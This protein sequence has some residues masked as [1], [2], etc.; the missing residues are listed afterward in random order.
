M[1]L[2]K[3]NEIRGGG[4]SLSAFLRNGVVVMRRRA[5]GALALGL[6]SA[7]SFAGLAFDA[8]YTADDTV[9]ISQSGSYLVTGTGGGSVTVSENVTGAELTI[10]NVTWTGNATKINIG[11]GAS[12]SLVLEG[13]SSIIHTGNSSGPGIKLP[14]TSSLTVFGTGELDMKVRN[15]WPCIGVGKT[16]TMGS[17]TI[18]GGT[19]IAYAEQGLSAAI[20]GGYGN[21]QR[22]GNGGTVVVNGGKLVAVGYS[23]APGIGGGMGYGAG[24]GGDAGTL[25]VNGGHVIAMTRHLGSYTGGYASPAIGPGASRQNV[26]K[27]GAPGRITVTGG[28][29]EAW[30]D[31]AEASCFGIARN[32]GQAA[33]VPEGAGLFVTGGT[34]K[35]NHLIMD[36]TDFTYSFANCNVGCSS[37]PER[38]LTG[39]WL[40][41]DADIATLF[42]AGV[43]FEKTPGVTVAANAI[44]LADLAAG[45]VA[46][47]S[48]SPFTLVGSSAATANKI[49]ASGDIEAALC[50]VN[51]TGN[52]EVPANSMS[53]VYVYGGNEIRSGSIA[54]TLPETG[55]LAFKGAG[56]LFCDASGN[57]CAIGVGEASKWGTLI[58]DGPTVQADGCYRSSGVGLS[59]SFNASRAGAG[60]VVVESGTLIANGRGFAPAIGGGSVH[61]AAPASV[62][63]EVIVKTNGT[64]YA[65]NIVDSSRS[66]ISGNPEKFAAGVAIGGGVRRQ[67]AE[68]AADAGSIIVDGGTIY[69]TVA[70]AAMPCFGIVN[71]M[72]T[73][74][75][76]PN[77]TGSL[78]IK[79]GGK[80]FFQH[81]DFPGQYTVTI[82][83]GT[84]GTMS[85][86]PAA[87]WVAFNSLS[88][89]TNALT[90]AG[91]VEPELTTL[92]SFKNSPAL[93]LET[94]VNI[95]SAMFPG[96][97]VEI[98]DME[99]VTLSSSIM[100]RMKNEDDRVLTRFEA[101]EGWINLAEQTG[102]YEITENG[103]YKFYGTGTSPVAIRVADNVEC[104]TVLADASINVDGGSVAPLELGAGSR[105]S[106][107]LMGANTMNRIGGSGKYAVI[108]V[109]KDAELTISDGAEEGEATGSLTIDETNLGTD[110]VVGIG[111]AGV[112]SQMGTL[113]I[114]SGNITITMKHDNNIHGGAAIGSAG[115]GSSCGTVT[116]NGGTVQLDGP[117]LGPAIGAGTDNTRMGH[118][119]NVTINGG[120]V[121][122]KGY[123]GASAIGLAPTYAGGAV[124]T[125]G[126]F[127]MNGG[128][129]FAYAKKGGSYGGNQCGAAI[130]GSGTRNGTTGSTIGQVTFNGG[131]AY[132]FSEG[133]CSIGCGQSS[134]GSE[135]VAR[136]ATDRVTI[137]GGNVWAEQG[138]QGDAVNA[139][140]L[141]LTHVAIQSS[142]FPSFPYTL[143]LGG[144]VAYTFPQTTFNDK[145]EHLWLPQGLCEPEND[146]AI[147]IG[148]ADGET[149]RSY[150][151][152][153]GAAKVFVVGKT[154]LS[155]S[156][157][158]SGAGVIVLGDGSETTF[159]GLD[160]TSVSGNGCHSSVVVQDGAT[161]KVILKGENS[162]KRPVGGDSVIHL[163]A[164]S[165]LTIDG[166]EDD[167][168]R[169]SQMTEGDSVGIGVANYD[170]TLSM[171]TFV[172]DGGNVEIKF[173][174]GSGNTGNIGVALGV[175]SGNRDA[176]TVI[177]NGG[178]LLA[179]SG[180][181]SPGIGGGYIHNGVAGSGGTVIVNGGVV[182]AKGYGGSAGIGG[183]TTYGNNGKCGKGGSF[184]LNG[185]TVYAYAYK[186][187]KYGTSGHCGAAI[188][189]PAQRDKNEAGGMGTVTINDGTLYAYTDV[190]A[191]IGHGN[192][193]SDTATA[194]IENGS[195]GAFTING[196]S[197]KLVSG[198]GSTTLYHVTPKNGTLE[199]PLVRVPARKFG[200]APYALE[201][202][203]KDAAEGATPFTY[204]YHGAGYGDDDSLYFYMPYGKYLMNGRF[205]EV[206]E[207]GVRF[208]GMT[209]I[210][211]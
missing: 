86:T 13:A 77:G 93:N 116:I 57:N 97:W 180:A 80:V 204:S 11:D 207:N 67:N 140:G 144:S 183:G 85:D 190:G 112:D 107:Q 176:G 178:T 69:A 133:A 158:L 114:D 61:K 141:T 58:V 210:V 164:G 46:L 44:G 170:K 81:S 195:D 191:A 149:P 145:L 165:K 182:T 168:L 82:D 101:R 211:K 181:L 12:L 157:A 40:P 113:T 92:P 39:L 196:G 75:Q 73:G 148:G 17:L 199:P 88:T 134:N 34:V 136:A 6:A 42:P 37:G 152:S 151:M 33:T 30:V 150:T 24:G 68:Y 52:W 16:E 9:T 56:W 7:L 169:I 201:F 22:G 128:T 126:T 1:K 79:N 132:L 98:G 147:V 163:P 66:G 122:A 137:T 203:E 208:S 197:V 205:C 156:S 64:L 59:Y 171:G 108:R 29:L 51:S 161:A 188:G 130:G 174:P 4:R 21:P 32:V 10:S 50:G 53:T 173:N 25:T 74:V 102:V 192:M 43:S 72:Q 3:M 49:V 62:G 96:E 118:G 155:S 143:D 18:N 125:P 120:T 65:N 15:F 127:T 106:L 78:T 115:R 31:R 194:T 76:N 135:P 91:P 153:S 55:T 26:A 124:G 103:E 38:K 202:V 104:T 71:G 193:A 206:A 111:E 35:W 185:G 162:L 90:I 8:E 198:S 27:H 83:D 14:Q 172:L 105:V 166:G 209:I 119:G 184:T 48:S 84:L 2:L 28:I 63:P 109:P 20:G 200:A 123:G 177:V 117:G 189:G 89:V 154:T 129:L 23:D 160:F 179:A 187:G 146:L 186:G 139:A 131:S 175:T 36:E 70:N 94:G 159:D 167:Y 19:I 47:D 121:I 87:S 60:K 45:D 54:W 99:K 41:V 95:L 5:R 138:I 100:R 110:H 142:V